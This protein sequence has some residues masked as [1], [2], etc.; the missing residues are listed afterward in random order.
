MQSETD[1]WVV[2]GCSAG[3]YYGAL[4]A[5][6]GYKVTII[7]KARR[8]ELGNRYDVIHVAAKEFER[9]GVPQPEPGDADYIRFFEL[10]YKKSALNNYPKKDHT[11]VLVLRRSPLMQ[12]IAKWA[13]AEGAE[14][15]FE[16]T[17][18]KSIFNASGIITGA[19]LK[20]A[21]GEFTV[22]ARLTAD[23]SG[24]PAVVRTSLPEDYGV[25]TFS[26]TN[27]D[28]FYVV[29][30]YAKMKNPED[31]PK[32]NTTWTHYKTWFAPAHIDGI[33]IMGVG[34]NL[35][36]E[37]AEAVFQR[38]CKKGFLPAYD[39]DHLEKGFTPYRRPP[40]SFVA[41]GFIALGDAACMTNPWSGEGGPYGWTLG[42]IAAG[43]Y[44]KALKAGGIPGAAAVWNINALYQA[45]QGADFA[46]NLA[47]LCGATNC[48]EKE[49]DY[50][51]KKDIIY[52]DDDKKAP[53]LIG[54]LLGGLVSGGISLKS[55]KNLIN[56]ASIGGKIKSHYLN[57]P[58]TPAEL[59]AW[60]A[61]ADKLWAKAG[62][63]AD[64][65]EADAKTLL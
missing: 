38:F 55:L 29:L 41:D 42:K 49:N 30:H 4:M 51:Y 23:A 13:Q 35:S 60:A 26:L 54:G 14:I 16:T 18:I 12:R 44:A 50:E 1:V 32:I 7:E 52:C 5:R 21:S 62:N 39:L 10:A 9:F 56:A 31:T 33:A 27:R 6:A 57:Y 17:F 15:R 43:E 20:D 8:E 61:V 25:E 63:M 19:V 47:M 65:A 40:Y 48:T 11:K 36:Y 22:N 53:N 46:M 24:I 45:E 28:Q 58:K 34:A 64:M 59:P 3:L 37:Y 2:G